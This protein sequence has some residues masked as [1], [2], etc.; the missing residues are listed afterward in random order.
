[1]EE[2]I[3][4]CSLNSDSTQNLL[5]NSTLLDKNSTQILIQILFFFLEKIKNPYF[6]ILYK[7]IILLSLN[8]HIFFITLIE[9]ETITNTK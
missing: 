4:R 9:K 7:Q 3:H 5:T 6:S 1:M 2:Q 8:W